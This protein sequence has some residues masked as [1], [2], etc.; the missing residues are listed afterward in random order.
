MLFIGFAAH[1]SQVLGD[2]WRFGVLGFGDC[3]LP[4]QAFT[5]AA[6]S[7]Y[8][9]HLARPQVGIRTCLRGAIGVEAQGVAG[10]PHQSAWL[11]HAEGE[12]GLFLGSVFSLHGR[13]SGHRLQLFERQSLVNYPLAE[14][15]SRGDE[16]LL[17]IGNPSL[18]SWRV[19]LGRGYAPFGIDWSE[20]PIFYRML[21]DRKFWDSP[22]KVAFVT[23]DNQRWLRFDVGYGADGSLS[24]GGDDGLLKGSG[25][26]PVRQVASVRS[27]VD[28]SAL[29]GTRIVTSLLGGKDGERRF[30]AGLINH[31]RRGDL[32]SFEFVRRLREPDGGKEPFAQLLRGVY[33]SQWRGG[34]RW[35][36]EIDDER[37]RSRRAIIAHDQRAMGPL[38]IRLGMGYLKS[39]SGD[40]VRRFTVILGTEARL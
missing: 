38:T 27:M 19:S 26:S 24:W 36:V 40:D 13:G 30:G 14:T 29:E 31:N 12:F 25:G 33:Q 21:E 8:S 18:D 16:L 10:G 23:W 11:D 1:A 34:R 15:A 20:A 32:T 5:D 6:A 22:R 17:Q 3:A 4:N 28:L 35:V 2:E 39:E 7:I 9:P 37:L